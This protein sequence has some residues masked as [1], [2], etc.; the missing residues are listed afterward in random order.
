M[1][2]YREKSIQARTAFAGVFLATLLSA[3]LSSAGMVEAERW[4]KLPET[5]YATPGSARDRDGDGLKDDLESRLA[6]TWRPFFVFDPAENNGAN[7]S[8]LS[9]QNW[10]PRVLFRVHPG[11]AL[12]ST[13]QV[14]R[15]QWGILF[16]MDGG[17]RASWICNNHHSGD[18]Q[19]GEYELISFDGGVNWRLDRINMAKAGWW[20]TNA[21]SLQVS[22]PVANIRGAWND[23]PLPM[24]YMS[25]GKHH[26]YYTGSQCENAS[27]CDEDCAGGATRIA[28]LM[29]WGYWL[30][31]GEPG[32][33]PTSPAGDNG[34][35][36]INRPFVNWLWHIG[37]PNENTWWANWQREGCGA[38]FTGGMNPGPGNSG[39]YEVGGGNTCT[40]P[41]NLLF[42]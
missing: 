30:N 31:V 11:P 10:E 22:G 29:P 42:Q 41:I 15:I 25:A 16:R 32:N 8:Q 5:I 18:S 35:N 39:A 6:D 7:T 27:G 20:W 13:S 12:P 28:H 19:G 1:N 34:G 4:I 26:Q 40:T 17:F 23:R 33:H 3:P 36:T 14:I 21:P 24:V 9:L 38:I 37:Y 2:H